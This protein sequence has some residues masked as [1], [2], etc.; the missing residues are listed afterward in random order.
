VSATTGVFSGTLNLGTYAVGQGYMANHTITLG[1]VGE[2]YGGGSSWNTNTAAL[3]LEC[4]DDTEIAVH[5]SGDRVSSLMYYQGGSGTKAPSITIGRDMGWGVTE[6]LYLL[7]KV[8]IN[9]TILGGNGPQAQLHIKC[10]AADN[11]GGIRIYTPS[12][13]SLYWSVYMMAFNDNDLKFDYRGTVKAIL[14]DTGSNNIA[15]NFTGQ[16]RTFIKD[17]PSTQASELEGLIVSADQN[18]YIKMSGGVETGPNAIT[19]NESLPI[20]SLSTVVRDKKCFGVVSASEDPDRREDT[21]GNFVSVLEKEGGDTRVYINSVGEGAMWVTS[22]NGNLESGDYITTSSIPGYGQKQDSEFLANYTVAKIT[23]DC[24]FEPVAQPVQRIKKELQYVNH[25]IKTMYETHTE[26]EY[27]KLAEEDRTTTIETV[28]T[29]EEGEITPEQYNILETNVQST[30]TELVRTIY[31]EIVRDEQKAEKEG[32]EL[33][34]R[35]EPVN[36]L[37]E[38]GEF[39][40]ENDP[41]GAM[42]KAYT[43]RFLLPT[44]EHI[45]ED[46]YTMRVSANDEA[47]VAAFVGC[48][49]HCG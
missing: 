33:E 11:T 28:Y 7:P 22:A 4:A 30:Y 38:H 47:Y 8:I 44:G 41:S 40:W 14:R 2:N 26:E 13:S 12:A 21:Y 5:D 37:N 35:H 15:L 31:L 49:Y 18:K 1:D 46:E 36:V 45:T 34:I 9:E 20:V 6:G 43:L 17:I 16:H 48:T 32:Y 42:E 10:S 39:Q 24:D 23:M 3:L 29:N 27:S 19:V 25:W